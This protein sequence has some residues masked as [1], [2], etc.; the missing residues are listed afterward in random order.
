MKRISLVAFLI[1]VMLLPVPAQ[2]YSN[3]LKKLLID[4]P[5]WTGEDSEGA[6]MFFNQVTM[7]TAAR[8][9]TKGDATIQAGIIIGNSSNVSQIPKTTYETDEGFLRTTKIK[10]YE[11]YLV[12]NK[13]DNSG[14]TFVLITSTPHAALFTFTYE[15]LGWQEAEALAKKFDLDAIKKVAENIK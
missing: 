10:G 7:I 2:Q 3:Q 14:S 11:T 4:L 15:N 8:Q 9:Y 5:G 6:D 13:T 1:S 12:Y